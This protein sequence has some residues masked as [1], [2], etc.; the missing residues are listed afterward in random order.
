MIDQQ[1]TNKLCLR[2]KG[3]QRRLGITGGIASGKT[4]IGDF[5]FQAK[6]WPILDA[7]VYAHEALRAE[8]QIVKKVLL[9]YGSKIIQNS[10]KSDQI[11]NRKALAKII[12][13]NHIEKKWLEGIIHP[14]VNKRIEEELEKLKS[15]SIVI[16]IIPLLFEKNYTGLCSEICYIDCPRDMQLQRLQSR[17]NLSLEEANQRIDAQWDNA[18]KKHFSDYIITNAN[19]DETWKIQLKKLYNF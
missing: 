2:W 18:L 11:I 19:N 3:K 1:Q 8:S 12:F 7:D 15:N 9:R 5:L 14:F 16:L 4:I 17:D 10:S 6:Q 13:Q